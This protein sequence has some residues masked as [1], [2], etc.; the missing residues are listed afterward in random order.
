MV[1]GCVQ[2]SCCA[3]LW[4]AVA[5]IGFLGGC[6]SGSTSAN[7]KSARLEGEVTLD[8]KPLDDGAI[9]FVPQDQQAPPVTVPILK[10]RYVA[11]KVGLGKVTVMLSGATAERPAVVS[12]SYTPPPSVTI[13]AR[14]KNGFPI[15]VKE[16]TADQNF[17]MSSK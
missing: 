10:G 11:S 12:S 14:Y 17:A 3:R 1:E 2:C 13:P 7:Y 6:G 4:V 16:D 5:L 9:Q 15:E 8:G